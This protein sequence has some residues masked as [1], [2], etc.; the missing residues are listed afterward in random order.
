MSWYV[1]C[2]PSLIA[3]THWIEWGRA[4]PNIL[5]AEGEEAPRKVL[6]TFR[7]ENVADLLP[8]DY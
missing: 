8:T 3:L 6:R 7:F 4:E 5:P 1:Q 2:E